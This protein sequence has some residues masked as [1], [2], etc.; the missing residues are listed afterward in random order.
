MEHPQQIFSAKIFSIYSRSSFSRNSTSQKLQW[1]P[2][3]PFWKQIKVASYSYFHY[4]DYSI[5]LTAKR[6]LKSITRIQGGVSE[7]RS[8][9][10]CSPS[11]VVKK[12]RVIRLRIISYVSILLIIFIYSCSAFY[13]SHWTS[14]RFSYNQWQK[15][16][17][18][19]LFG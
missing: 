12:E 8:Y 11:Y 3:T 14:W 16:R 19:L 4:L 13:Y 9:I 10:I 6:I 18:K 5:F 2:N 7:L 15:L 17:E 1:V